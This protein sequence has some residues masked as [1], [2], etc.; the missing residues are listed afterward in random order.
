MTAVKNNL[1]AVSNR[2]YMTAVKNNLT[3]VSV[4]TNVTAVKNNLTAVYR[5]VC[6]QCYDCIIGRAGL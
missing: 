1:T 3:A 2:L 5:R 6:G 4:Q